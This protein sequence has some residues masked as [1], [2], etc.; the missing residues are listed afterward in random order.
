MKN[1]SIHN[2]QLF[3]NYPNPFNSTTTIPFYLSAVTDII[4]EI[5]DIQ[6]KRIRTLFT[7]IK[8]AGPH[9]LTWDGKTDSGDITV[10]GVYFVSMRQ[11]DNNIKSRSQK[12]ILLK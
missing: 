3:T 11:S 4:I 12:I 9:K 8:P 5:Y 2:F 10:S 7:G 1:N 6:G